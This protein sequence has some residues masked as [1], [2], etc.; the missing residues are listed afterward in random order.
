MSTLNAFRKESHSRTSLPAGTRLYPLLQ[1]GIVSINQEFDFLKKLLS[2]QVLRYSF[3][4]ET[5]LLFK[6]IQLV[7]KTQTLGTLRSQA[8]FIFFSGP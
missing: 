8:L 1:M 3:R 6:K 5:S 2:V 7:L 4:I